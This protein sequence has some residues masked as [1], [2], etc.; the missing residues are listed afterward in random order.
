MKTEIDWQADGRSF[1]RVAEIYDIFRPG[2]PQEL[3][4]TILRKA[5][6]PDGGKILEIGSGTG[7]ATLPFA[8]RGCSILCIEPGE[9]LARVAQ[10]NLRDWPFVSWE[11]VTFQDWQEPLEEFDLVISAQ[12]FHWVP[13]PAGYIKAAKVLKRGASLAIF[14]NMRATN[15][16]PVFEELEQVYR[17]RAPDLDDNKSAEEVIQ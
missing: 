16:E 9:N 3:V 1:D 17:E 4:D 5:R 15:E 10:K 14:W 6:L 11:I 13:R 12:A 7:K 2:Y 8:R